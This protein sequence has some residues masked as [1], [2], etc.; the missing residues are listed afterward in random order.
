MK[1]K[2]E[3]FTVICKRTYRGRLDNWDYYNYYIKGK[4]YTFL[5]IGNR[6]LVDMNILKELG[7]VQELTLEEI[8][9]Y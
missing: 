9:N 5:V 4:K 1:T 3:E 2:L 6:N 7:T 8:F